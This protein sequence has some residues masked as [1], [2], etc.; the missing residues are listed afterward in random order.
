MFESSLLWQVV[1][2]QNLSVFFVQIRDKPFNLLS[3]LWNCIFHFSLWILLEPFLLLFRILNLFSDSFFFILYLILQIV[4]LLISLLKQ[5]LI[6]LGLFLIL[7]AFSP[8]LVK[9]PLKTLMLTLKFLNLLLMI[10][11]GFLKLFLTKQPL[12]YS[13]LISIQ[14]P[15]VLCHQLLVFYHRLVLGLFH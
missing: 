10:F 14:N 5:L 11:F 13:L 4:N 1:Q 3:Q 9:W 2:A 7:L 8:A 15:D 12:L 6:I